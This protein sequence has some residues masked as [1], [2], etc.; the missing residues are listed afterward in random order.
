MVARH[1]SAEFVDVL[2][3]IVTREPTRSGDSCNLRPPRDA[4]GASCPE[5]SRRARKTASSHFTPTDSPGSI[6]QLWFAKSERDLLASGLFG[7]VADLA[8]AF[9]WREVYPSLVQKG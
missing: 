7:L 9:S 6:D 4:Q 1:T 8:V 2:G 5:L 3:E